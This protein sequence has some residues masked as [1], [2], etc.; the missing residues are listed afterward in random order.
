[1]R[2]VALILATLGILCLAAGQ[3][4]AHEYHHGHHGYPGHYAYYRA[5]VVVRAAPVV[6][7]YV[8]YPPVCRP[9]PYYYYPAPAS[10]FY[11]QGRGLSIGIGF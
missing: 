6:V 1:M 8:A 11:Y 7:P 3:L 2:R 5:P 10:G 9:W 4:Q